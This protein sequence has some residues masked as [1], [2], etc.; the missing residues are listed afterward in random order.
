MNTNLNAT[1]KSKQAIFSSKPRD[2]KQALSW[3]M[4]WAIPKVFTITFKSYRP[5]ERSLKYLDQDQDHTLKS[6]LDQRSDH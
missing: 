4:F 5:R 6:D 2:F 1:V 3:F